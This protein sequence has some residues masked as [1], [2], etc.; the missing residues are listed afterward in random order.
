LAQTPPIRKGSGFRHATAAGEG[1]MNGARGMAY[2]S[3]RRP[4]RRANITSRSVATFTGTTAHAVKARKP[5]P[6]TAARASP[7]ERAPIWWR[8]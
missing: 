1:E 8:K 4:I 3:F 7:E 6:L 2:R 5:S